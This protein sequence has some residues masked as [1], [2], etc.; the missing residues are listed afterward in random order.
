[1]KIRQVAAELFNANGR[2]NSNNEA[3]SRFSQ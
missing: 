1:M 3:N 2:K